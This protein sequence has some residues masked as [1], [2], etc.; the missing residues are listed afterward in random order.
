MSPSLQ[1]AIGWALNGLAGFV[2]YKWPQLLPEATALVGLIIGKLHLK[3]PVLDSKP[4]T[5]TE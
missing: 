2:A 1:Y 5:Q 3:Q 4:K